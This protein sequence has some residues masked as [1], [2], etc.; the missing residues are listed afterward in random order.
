MTEAVPLGELF[1]EEALYGLT[2][3]KRW[4]YP[5]DVY[6]RL[7][8]ASPPYISRVVWAWQDPLPTRL[9]RVGKMYR[10]CGGQS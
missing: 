4:E 10:P 2:A 8:F 6:T 7:D 3:Q 5:E 9:K 1:H